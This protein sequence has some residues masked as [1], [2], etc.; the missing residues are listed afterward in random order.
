MKKIAI[1]TTNG[2]EEV[3]LTSP[4]KFLKEKGY[5]VDIVA[6]EDKEAKEKGKVRAWQHTDWG[7]YYDI[8]VP[9]KD[10]KADD[11]AA[12]VLPGGVINPDKLRV[13]EASLNFI[14]SFMN[15]GKIVAAI[16]HGPWTLLE[17]GHVKGRKITSVKNISTD[18]KNAG[19]LWEDKSVIIDKNLI[20]S[21]TPE[22]LS[23]F[24]HAI[25][26][27]LSKA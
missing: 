22:D 6:P 20:T 17:R 26:E 10:A 1:L 18:L 19:G 24:N 27:Q 9:L 7:P 2:F 21:R 15:K 14:D 4:M 11:Y 3:E 8:T 12:L 13:C 16:C 23:D 25:V 5:Q